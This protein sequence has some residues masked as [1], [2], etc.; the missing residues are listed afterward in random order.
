MAILM[1]QSV[2]RLTAMTR[3]E[4]VRDQLPLEPLDDKVAQEARWTADRI[5]VLSP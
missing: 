2:R 1:K 3:D 5:L 4:Y